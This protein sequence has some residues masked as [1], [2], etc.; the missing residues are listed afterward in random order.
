MR[1]NMAIASDRGYVTT[2]FTCEMYQAPLIFRDEKGLEKVGDF[3]NTFRTGDTWRRRLA[4]G[5]VVALADQKG[6]TFGEAVVVGIHCGEQ[7]EMLDVYAKNNHMMKG[8]EHT[9]SSASVALAAVLKK[10]Y[11]HF[12]A[13]DTLLTVIELKRI[14]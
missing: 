13:R 5:E 14:S 12:L 2:M 1:D 4:K 8:E 11:G 6:V 3:A 9:R 10:F 7:F